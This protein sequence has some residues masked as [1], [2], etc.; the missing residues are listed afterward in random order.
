MKKSLLV[1]S[2]GCTIAA[3][4]LQATN[5]L[6]TE[7]YS[8]ATSG[9]VL[10]SPA[11]P[12]TVW[13]FD[14]AS[15]AWTSNTVINPNN[16]TANP[17]NALQIATQNDVTVAPT[18]T[19]NLTLSTSGAITVQNFAL[20]PNVTSGIMTFT[21][22]GNFTQY[23]TSGTLTAITGATSDAS[24]LIIDMNGYNMTIGRGLVGATAAS[25]FTLNSTVAGG[26]FTTTSALSD[27]GASARIVI[28]NGATLYSG[29]SLTGASSEVAA[30][31]T[32]NTVFAENSTLELKGRNTVGSGASQLTTH[33][34]VAGSLNGPLGNLILGDGLTGTNWS[35][36]GSWGAVGS[37]T[38]LG[39]LMTVKGYM[40][41]GL[42]ST[43]AFG[44][45]GSTT[46]LAGIAVGGNYTDL[47]T[48]SRSYS[49]STATGAVNAGMFFN[50]GYTSGTPLVNERTLTINGTLTKNATSNLTTNFQVGD[51]TTGGNIKLGGNFTTTDS[52]F[53]VTNNSRLNLDTK[54]LSSAGGI[55]IASG[56]TIA[57]T[58]GNFGATAGLATTAGVLTL[59]TF[60][61]QLNY[62]GTGWND[63]DALLLFHYGSQ[64][65][66][67]A[68]GTVT[69]S[70]TYGSLF[71]DGAGNIY[72]TN[73]NAPIPIPE[74]GSVALLM[75]GIGVLVWGVRRKRVS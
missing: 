39:R 57:L 26:V 31:Y 22:G 12:S 52:M 41:V 37:P 74:P 33:S 20:T 58:F 24:R 70:G 1:F 36:S 73:I 14:S 27:S 62:D 65:G 32:F 56:G 67:I 60:N 34:S 19:G 48:G 72:L 45:A 28:N 8:G 7:H 75:A 23:A 35:F 64:L 51:G 18:L 2:I 53:T 6:V 21:L 4:S 55:T 69:Y 15:P 9:T 66:A 13:T 10:W 29:V 3:T 68:L 47:N 46:G 25:S 61:L 59:N 17:S 30:F 16:G 49:V 71:D 42:G 43:I 54:T 44:V 11:T 63:G 5:H 38:P 50:G 40:T